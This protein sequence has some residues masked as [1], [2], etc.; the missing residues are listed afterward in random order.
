MQKLIMDAVTAAGV[1][2]VSV[3]SSAQIGKTEIML[4][5]AGYY[6]DYE[7]VPQMAVTPT[8]EMA[9]AFSRNRLAR[10]IDD[11]ACLRGK[12]SG[13]GAERKTGNSIL[14]KEYPG[15]E[16]TGAGANSPASLSG[17]PKAVVQ[18]DDIDR[19]KMTKEGDPLQ[20]AFKRT[21]SFTKKK[22]IAFSTPTIKGQSKIEDRWE[23]SNKTYFEIPCP[24]TECGHW[25]VMRFDQDVFK[26]E[27]ETDNNGH[28][29]VLDAWYE[30]EKCHAKITERARKRVLDRMRTKV[31]NPKVKKHI[32]FHCWEIYNPMS[33]MVSIAQQY[34]DS[35]DDPEKYQVFVNTVLGQLWEVKAL[36]GKNADEFNQRIESYELAPE[37]VLI[38]TCA[39]D[40]QENRLEYQ[41]QGWG[42]REECWILDRGIING[43]YM[44]TDTWDRLHIILNR[45]IEY[46][47]GFKKMID[48]VGID[49][50]FKATVVYPQVRRV[51]ALGIP[52]V[53]GIKGWTFQKNDSVIYKQSTEK[54]YRIRLVT[55]NVDRAKDILF[56]R[57][58]MT[59]ITGQDENEGVIHFNQKCDS[60]FFTQLTAE[61]KR[62]KVVS[63]R[64]VQ[65]WEKKNKNDA[66]EALDLTVYN[67]ALLN[68]LQP[69]KWKSVKK[70]IEARM[71]AAEAP[72]PKQSE[73]APPKVRRDYPRR[74]KRNGYKPG[75]F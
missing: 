75:D 36:L 66:N 54:K 8:L 4:C 6:M 63:N 20:L 2:D 50:G 29:I 74:P 28:Y 58:D 41:I 18:C 34:L 44:R 42:A 10:M 31:T 17:H 51:M 9:R 33:T 1:E 72:P 55:V 61:V 40:V 7:P 15:G 65:V 64:L 68:L 14:H 25:Q 21:T 35:K 26:F 67:L 3:M 59:P 60:I 16:Y 47:N 71:K 27:Y 62:S 46:Q 32:G 57:L 19:F 30:C 70:N 48:A 12:V 5:I 53:F 49:T 11:T 56:T 23:R 24:N 43:P 45:P 22:R 69:I 73:D 37:R 38:I 39:V 52:H 13:A